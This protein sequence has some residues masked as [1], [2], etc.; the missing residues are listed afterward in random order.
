MSEGRESPNGWDWKMILPSW[1][2]K[3]RGN[4]NL[5]G[6]TVHKLREANKRGI[7]VTASA[8]GQGQVTGE[9]NKVVV[10]SNAPSSPPLDAE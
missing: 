9:V 8:N 10:E 4:V 2:K 6:I 7:E 3:G 1:M 5:T